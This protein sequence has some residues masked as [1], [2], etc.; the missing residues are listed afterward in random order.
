MYGLDSFFAAGT[1]CADPETKI[2]V[3]EEE[4]GGEDAAD[5]GD[6]SSIFSVL[7]SGMIHE[8]GKVRTILT[9]HRGLGRELMSARST[10]S[11]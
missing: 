9:D 1:R 10:T 5:D 11:L 3:S 7:E 8:K 6:I 4:S 2:T